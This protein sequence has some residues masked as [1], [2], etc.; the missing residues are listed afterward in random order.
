MFKLSVNPSRDELFLW[1][2]QAIANKF[3]ERAIL[4]GGMVLRLLESPRYTNDLDYM[5]IPYKSK[6]EIVGLMETL[7]KSIPNAKISKTI[8]SKALHFEIQVNDMVV[9]VE[10][11]VATECPSVPISTGALAVPLGQL[12]QIIRVMSYDVALAHK[13]AAWNERRIL[14]DLYDVYFF[15][16]ILKVKPHKT[17][18]LARLQKIE[19]RLPALKTIKKMTAL[20]FASELNDELIKLSDKRI[21]NELGM[22]LA[23]ENLAGLEKKMQISL[24]ALLEIISRF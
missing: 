22:I 23:K 24:Q 9:Q 18:L 8:S 7:L 12:N 10:V 11:N 17:T 15:H 6:N 5:L 13:L 3:Q 20:Q 16:S 4:R 2:I 1:I 19:T 21:A 14:R